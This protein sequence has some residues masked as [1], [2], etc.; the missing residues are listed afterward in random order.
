MN[1]LVLPFVFF[2]LISCKKAPEPNNTN[3]N[4]VKAQDTLVSSKP[5]QETAE[6]ANESS[7]NTQYVSLPF[8]YEEYKKTCIQEGSPDCSKK[9]PVLGQLES[10]KIIKIIGITEGSP[11]SIFQIQSASGSPINIY[12]LNFEGDSNSQELITVNNDKIISRQ[13]IGYAMPEEETYETFIMNPDMTV[14]I[15]EISFTDSSNKKK[16]EKYKIAPT[17]KISKI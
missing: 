16:K 3:Q 1:K 11:E 7:A 6:P 9:Y 8:N 13:S 17:G 4:A 5:A 10:D 15:Y 12:V 2:A 14:D